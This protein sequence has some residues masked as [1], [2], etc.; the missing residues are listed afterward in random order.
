[1]SSP[2]TLYSCSRKSS[3]NLISCNAGPP[4]SIDLK[5]EGRN[6][7]RE[8]VGR[9]EV[10]DRGRVEGTRGWNQDY[11]AGPCQ[12]NTACGMIMLQA[13]KQTS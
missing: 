7:R 2:C 11:N 1:M 10:R 12:G 6:R 4:R 8:K 5:D 9:K 3:S 13:S